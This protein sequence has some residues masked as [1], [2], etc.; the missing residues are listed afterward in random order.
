MN[1]LLNFDFYNTFKADLNT[2]TTYCQ[3][4]IFSQQSNISSLTSAQKEKISTV[5]MAAFRMLATGFMVL[6]AVEAITALHLTASAFGVI[7]VALN[8]FLFIAARDCFVI[9]RANENLVNKGQVSTIFTT[10]R[11]IGINLFNGNM[12]ESAEMAQNATSVFTKLTLKQYNQITSREL[13]TFAKV[14]TVETY[15]KSLWQDVMINS[16][17]KAAN[18]NNTP[19]QA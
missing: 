13:E 4:N 15:F 10:V 17:R 3:K 6:F 5:S 11:A 2:L 18:L 7:K 12:T 14:I 1:D 9:S 19:I 16:I 8:V